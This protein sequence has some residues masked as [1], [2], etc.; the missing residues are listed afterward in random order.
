M[1]FAGFDDFDSCVRT[2]MDDEGHD[3]VSAR[4]IC[5]ALE[6]EAKAEN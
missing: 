1:P 2:M 5:G 3:E 6:E 4:S